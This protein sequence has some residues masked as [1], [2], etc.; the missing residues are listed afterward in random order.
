MIISKTAKLVAMA[1]FALG[2]S[3]GANATTT[4]LGAL[5]HGATA[6]N[7]VVPAAGPFVD[8]YTFSLPANGGSGYSVLNF[9]LDIPNVGSFNTAFSFLSLWSNPDGILYNTDDH[10]LKTVTGSNANGLSFNW[11][12]NASGNLYLLVGGVA[13]GSL[14]G[15]YSGAISAAVPEPYEWAMMIA[16]LG[17]VG[18]MRYKRR[19]QKSAG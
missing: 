8:V 5:P 13:N 12:S 4:N 11:G 3:A 14:G 1:A 18:T 16:G 17:L 7:G 15:L 6:F 2:C 9:P 10:E 19:N